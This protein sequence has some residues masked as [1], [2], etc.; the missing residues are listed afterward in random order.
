[1][2]QPK[3]TSIDLQIV[4]IHQ[5][6]GDILAIEFLKNAD[7]HWVEGLFLRAKKFGRTEFLYHEKQYEIIKNRNLTYTIQEMQEKVEFLESL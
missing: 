5:V 1:M 2:L 4:N 7:F 3:K 6:N